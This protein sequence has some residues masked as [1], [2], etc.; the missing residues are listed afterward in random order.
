VVLEDI[1]SYQNLERIQMLFKSKIE[2]ESENIHGNHTIKPKEVTDAVLVD[3]Q[4]KSLGFI[5]KLQ[6]GIFGN[7]DYLFPIHRVGGGA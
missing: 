3:K 4:E 2:L 6:T 5:K 7:E 1:Q